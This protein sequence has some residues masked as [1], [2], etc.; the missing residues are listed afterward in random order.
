MVGYDSWKDYAHDLSLDVKSLHERLNRLE[1]E[2]NE[3]ARLYSQECAHVAAIKREQRDA[4]RLVVPQGD[5]E[6][7]YE[8]PVPGCW[9]RVLE[10]FEQRY[11]TQCGAKFDWQTYDDYCESAI[12]AAESEM[13][14]R[15]E[16][17][18]L[19]CS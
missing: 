19:A 13:E 11:C 8:C 6:L 4:G 3:Y 12:A 16:E 1:A 9:A 17:A 7:G 14:W 18:L 10:P 5:M 15:R 2:R